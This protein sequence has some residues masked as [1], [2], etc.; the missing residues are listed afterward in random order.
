MLEPQRRA[1]LRH[2]RGEAGPAAPHRLRLPR[3][4]GRPVADHRDADEPQRGGP[5]RLHPLPGQGDDRA[6][7]EDRAPVLGPRERLRRAGELSRAGRRR[8]GLDRHA[9]VQLEGAVQRPHRRR[10][11]P[12]ARRRA[13][14]VALA[15]ALRRPPAARHRPA[16]R[17]ARQPVL[18][19]QA[20]PARARAG[21][22]PL[23][24][25]AP[26]HPRP[27]GGDDPPHGR[28][29][30]REPAPAGDGDHAR[31][32]V[33]RQVGPEGA[34]GRCPPTAGSSPSTSGCGP[35]RRRSGCR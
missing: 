9:H 11:R 1:D 22:H 4:Q 17:D 26:G 29:R 19:R 15:A 12:P 2:G 10:R 33:A 35:S 7:A 20:D 30:E 25:L 14:H 3:P 23:L 13:R 18:P 5:Q 32:R 28:L 21:R 27:Q 6:A 8:T 34:A 31:L 16:L 24:P